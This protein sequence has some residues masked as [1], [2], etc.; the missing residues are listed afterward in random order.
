MTTTKTYDITY[1]GTVA[2][3]EATTADADM[4]SLDQLVAD[5]DGSTGTMRIVRP[6]QMAYDYVPVARD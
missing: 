1:P 5:A 4:K 2:C 3:V 6:T